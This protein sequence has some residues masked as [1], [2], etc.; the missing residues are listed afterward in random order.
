MDIQRSITEIPSGVLRKQIIIPQ[1]IMQYWFLDVS[2]ESVNSS[3]HTSVFDTY[4]V[5]Y[6]WS[7]VKKISIDGLFTAGVQNAITYDLEDDNDKYKLYQN[8]LAINNAGS[9]SVGGVGT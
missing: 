5:D 9:L 2:I 8:Y 3:E 1:S 7:T 6:A 4:D